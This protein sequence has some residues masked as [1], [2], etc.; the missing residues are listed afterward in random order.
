MHRLVG[1]AAAGTLATAAW[2]SATADRLSAWIRRLDLTD[3]A[4]WC[5]NVLDV[6][7]RRIGCR[8]GELPGRDRAEEGRGSA[9]VVDLQREVVEIAG[10]RGASTVLFRGGSRSVRSPLAWRP[11][12]TRHGSKPAI[13]VLN[14][15]RWPNGSR[16]VPMRLPWN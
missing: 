11:G 7:S 2:M 3:A 1:C 16:T 13:G 14:V 4:R 15:H 10:R 9:E 5:G 6:R 12:R 8:I